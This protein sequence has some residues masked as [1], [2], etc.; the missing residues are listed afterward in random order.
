MSSI[1]TPKS[2]ETGQGTRREKWRGNP[3]LEEGL[4]TKS[5]WAGG[6]SPDLEAFEVL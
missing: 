4:E 2:E 1:Q 3:C 5:R 6:Q